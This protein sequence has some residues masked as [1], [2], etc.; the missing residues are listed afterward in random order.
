MTLVDAF[1]TQLE[2][3]LEP[4]AVEKGTCTRVWF[5]LAA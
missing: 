1:V 2:G 5:P 4:V 3:R